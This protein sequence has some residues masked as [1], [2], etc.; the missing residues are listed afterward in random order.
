MFANIPLSYEY[1]E[2]IETFNLRKHLDETI[3]N[4]QDTKSMKVREHYRSQLDLLN[5]VTI[6]TWGETLE[7]PKM[8]TD[9]FFQKLCFTGLAGSPH[10]VKFIRENKPFQKRNIDPAQLEKIQWTMV[11]MLIDK[12]RRAVL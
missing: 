12:Y 8:F 11:I 4:P 1:T 7:T 10:L 3:E 9:D 2:I 5:Q 6:N